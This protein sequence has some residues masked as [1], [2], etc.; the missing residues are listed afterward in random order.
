MAEIV[1]LRG[2]FATTIV[3][4][5]IASIS[6]L[7]LIVFVLGHLAGN[8]LLFLGPDQFNAYAAHLKALGPVLS[9]MRTVMLTALILHAGMTVWLKL[10]N[11]GARGGRYAVTTRAASRSIGTR[12]M[13]YT[14]I[15]IFLFLFL[16]VYDFAFA[17]K[18]GARSLIHGTS[19]G[20]YGI[21]FNSFANPVRSALYVAAVWAVGFHFSHVLSSL[22]V[23]L[24]ALNDRLT[25][26]I[27]GVARLF[28]VLLAL[29]YTSIPVFVLIKTFLFT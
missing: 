19:L 13:I 1:S 23:T 3:I 14:G 21:V 8:F 16:H 4:E 18:A 27:D 28:G 24:G 17:D 9:L 7:G 6:G 26:G 5:L 11:M 22:W 12:T 2:R 15:I 25:G 20:L 10:R 29:G